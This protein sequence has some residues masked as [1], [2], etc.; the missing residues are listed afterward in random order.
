MDNRS[1]VSDGARIFDYMHQWLAAAVEPGAV[2][3]EG[4]PMALLQPDDLGQELS[5][6]IKVS[7]LNEYMI[8]FYGSAFIRLDGCLWF[9]GRAV[10]FNER[11]LVL[12]LFR[13]NWNNY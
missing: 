13:N 4:W 5:H 12:V 7:R 10:L 9:F 8:E 2:K 1:G 11:T 3:R 6:D